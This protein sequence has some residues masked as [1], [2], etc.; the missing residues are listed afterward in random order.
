MFRGDNLS[1]LE[2]LTSIFLLEAVSRISGYH[3]MRNDPKPH[4]LLVELFLLDDKDALNL[5]L[6]GEV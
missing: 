2:I 6:P 1:S 3:D 5:S 4:N